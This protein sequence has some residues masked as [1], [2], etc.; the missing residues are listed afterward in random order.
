MKK[1]IIKDDYVKRI[2]PFK[3]FSTILLTV[4]FLSC[5][6]PIL[7]IGI[8]SFKDNI[9]L[10]QNPW[11]LPINATL[12]NYRK[13]IVDYGM[14]GF[15]KNS[16]IIS[17]STVFFS[18]TF[19]LM[20]TFGMVRLRWRWNKKVLK[21]FLLGLMIPAYGCL[22]PM[23]SI[24]MKLNLLNN[25]LSVIIAQVTFNMPTSILIMSGFFSTIPDGIEEAAIIDGC[26]ARDIFW[27]IDCPIVSS[28]IVTVAIISFV[29]AWNDLLYS[30]IF[31]TADA[32]MPAT[33]GLLKFCGLHG[34]DSAGMTA[35]VVIIVIPVVIVYTFLHKYI[36][37]GIIAGAVKG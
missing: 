23:F 11:G 31:L 17:L 36:M 29:S 5:V 14:L 37:E 15:F 10:F 28:G 3:I 27:R 16:V 9:E 33:V 7:W 19:S 2:T 4:F 32:K 13:A 21:L 30:Q 26:N 34:A 12:E 25:R 20:A 18:I 24:F 8:N 6:Y 35:A 22:I 1:Q